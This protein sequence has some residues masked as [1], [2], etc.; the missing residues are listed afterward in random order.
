MNMKCKVLLFAS[1]L[2]ILGGVNSVFAY[3][4]KDAPEA[5]TLNPSS[6]LK[7]VSPELRDGVLRVVVSTDG[8]TTFNSFVLSNPSRVV[9]DFPGLRNEFGAKTIPGTGTAVE[10]V[11]VGQPQAGT[12]RVVL[13]LVR[14]VKYTVTREGNTVVISIPDNGF[15]PHIEL[16]K[17]M[18]ANTPNRTVP[19]TE[20]RGGVA[21][22]PRVEI[23]GGY[24]YIR[25]DLPGLGDHNASGWTSAVSTNF[26]KYLGFTSEISGHWASTGFTD[27]KPL[28][29]LQGNGNLAYRSY[30]LMGGPRFTMRD[31][32]MTTYAH[33]LFGIGHIAFNKANLTDLL[34]LAKSLGADPETQISGFSSNSF[35][36]AFGGGIDVHLTPAVSLRVIQ[37]EYLLTHFRDLIDVERH[38]QHNIRVSFGIAFRLGEVR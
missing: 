35:A 25:T 23:F 2:T 33:A 15:S 21:F 16:S 22:T 31:H 5:Q 11:R 20:Q 36:A 24:Q 29:G 10:R 27:F 1:L 19:Q 26:N 6:K 7:G 30:T 4:G 8:R 18:S 14:E 9:V 37:A 3:I 34:N 13:D 28:E 12:V 17:S 38:N 32:R